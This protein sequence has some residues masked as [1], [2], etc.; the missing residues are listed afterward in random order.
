MPYALQRMLQ[1]MHEHN[2]T[3]GLH[4]YFDNPERAPVYTHAQLRR[5][6]SA[7]IPPFKTLRV[8]HAHATMRRAVLVPHQNI[9]QGEDSWLVRDLWTR[10]ETFVYTA[11]PLTRYIDR[12]G[13]ARAKHK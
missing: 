7:Q 13:R 5:H 11:E 1:L 8:H 12:S 10:N 4:S 2:A 6:Y 9:T 3:V